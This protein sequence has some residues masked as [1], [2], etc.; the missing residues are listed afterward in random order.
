[1]ASIV[2]N[3]LNRLPEAVFANSLSYLD[4]PDINN[5]LKTDR[6]NNQITTQL[7]KHPRYGV[8]II[9]NFSVAAIAG[10]LGEYAPSVP[11]GGKWKEIKKIY[12]KQVDDIF[13]NKKF[14]RGVCIISDVCPRVLGVKIAESLQAEG[15]D[16]QPD[17][18][19]VRVSLSDSEARYNKDKVWSNHDS[20]WLLSASVPFPRFEF[21]PASL[22]ANLKQ[23]ETLTFTWN[24]RTISVQ[25]LRIGPSALERRTVEGFGGSFG[26]LY[27]E[28]AKK[29]YCIQKL[30]A[31]TEE[32]SPK[33]SI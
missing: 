32:P 1:M 7:L 20:P 12:Q 4:A 5:L 21:I 14:Y 8:A 18:P 3:A 25:I 9:S 17:T 13:T 31:P 11:E 19:F 2:S 6:T 30:P 10:A 29:N 28:Q 27:V 24:E 26:E 23:G 22:I 33:E 15:Y 16:V